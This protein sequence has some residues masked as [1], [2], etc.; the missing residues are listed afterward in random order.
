MADTKRCEMDDCDAGH[1][2]EC[3]GHMMQWYGPGRTCD[4]CIL[5]S[6]MEREAAM[7][8]TTDKYQAAKNWLDANCE[9]EEAGDDFMCRLRNAMFGLNYEEGCPALDY[10]FEL[11]AL[12]EARKAQ[13]ERDAESAK[14]FERFGEIFDLAAEDDELLDDL[15]HTLA[16]SSASAINNDGV[17]S[18]I[19]FVV[20]ELGESEAIHQFDFIVAS[21]PAK[22]GA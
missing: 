12:D 18:Q 9:V 16:A 22:D 13:E 7:E 15:V 19:E 1:C 8:N 14:K 3:G 17:E 6:D 2:V 10:I 4:E 5:Q 11:V 21:M 20:R